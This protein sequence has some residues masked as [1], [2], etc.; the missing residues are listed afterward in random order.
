[1]PYRQSLSRPGSTAKH[2]FKYHLGAPVSGTDLVT[3]V[4][5]MKVAGGLRWA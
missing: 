1:M 2:S 3:G 5:V 4:T